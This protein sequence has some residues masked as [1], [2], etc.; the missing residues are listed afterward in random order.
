M[1][2]LFP[3]IVRKLI[4]TT[5]IKT[6]VA[7]P[8]LNLPKQFFLKPKPKV[9]TK[10]VLKQIADNIYNPKTGHYLNLCEG[11]LQNGPDPVCEARTMHC[12]L[13]ELYFVV[14]G[15]HPE[16]DSADEGFVIDKITNRS[17]I[18][19]HE[20]SF[21]LKIKEAR[22]KIRQLD[23]PCYTTLALENVLALQVYEQ[24]ELFRQCLSEIPNENDA[25][26]IADFQSRAK[27]VAAV[28][29]KAAEILPR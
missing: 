6:K 8:K 20:G 28:L 16:E 1:E 2:L 15:R 3:E 26:L 13:G 9:V 22:K 10:K 18:W 11:T 25:G 14:T 27:R 19:E 7:K 12:G 4:M 5:K 24:E 17:T 23:L 29:R 21:Q